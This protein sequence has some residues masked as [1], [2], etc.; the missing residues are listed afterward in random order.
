MIATGTSLVVVSR[1]IASRPLFTLSV[2]ESSFGK[3]V[4][5]RVFR[6]DFLSVTTCLSEV[7]SDVL[8]A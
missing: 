4:S 8:G 1:K 3:N 2:S 6:I 5:A 7:I